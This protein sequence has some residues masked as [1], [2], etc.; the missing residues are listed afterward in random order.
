MNQK[1]TDPRTSAAAAG[2]SP[3]ASVGDLM[4]NLKDEAT[5]LF[6]D[7]VDLAK[8]EISEKASNAGRNLLFV[9]GGALVAYSGLVILLLSIGWL[10]SR[11]FVASGVSQN[12]A[13]FLGLLIVGLVVIAGSAALI[14]TGISRLK[15][16]T[17]KPEKTISSLSATADWGEEKLQEAKMK[18]GGPANPLTGNA[19]SR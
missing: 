11:G 1:T 8:A 10:I 17:L 5:G 16:Q 2:Q 13:V 4:R 12:L 3:E 6:R 14:G 15:Q 19:P 18:Q 9:T 7:E